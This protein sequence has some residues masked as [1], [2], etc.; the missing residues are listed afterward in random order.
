MPTTSTGILPALVLL[1]WGAG[2]SFMPLLAIAMED[3]PNEDAGLGSGIVNVSMQMASAVGLALLGTIATNRTL[4]LTGSGARHGPA[5]VAEPAC[6]VGAAFVAIG[7]VVAIVRVRG[8][9]ATP[10]DEEIASLEAYEAIET[11]PM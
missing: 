8:S 5:L 6:L 11:V 9:G 1:G 7:T 4:E 3:V 2:T 10:D